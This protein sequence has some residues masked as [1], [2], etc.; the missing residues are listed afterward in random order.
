M[1]VTATITL[2]A[3]FGLAGAP[4]FSTYVGKA[5]IDEAAERGGSVWPAIVGLIASALTAAA[6]FRAAGRVFF[7]WGP[8][9]E[10][11]AGAATEQESRETKGGR[12]RVPAFMLAPPLSMISLALAMG[13]VPDL[14]RR[15]EVQAERFQDRA[16]YVHAVLGGTRTGAVANHARNDALA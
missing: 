15:L 7:G 13:L 12:G 1:P 11:E 14:Q 16:A 8:P 4:P 2:L 5:I 3:A 10:E 6:V 9:P